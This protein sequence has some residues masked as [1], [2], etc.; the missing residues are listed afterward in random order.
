[1]D[2]KRLSVW[3]KDQSLPAGGTLNFAYAI[4]PRAGEAFEGPAEGVLV[5]CDRS[6]NKL[7]L[8]RRF[9]ICPHPHKFTLFTGPWSK[10]AD[11]LGAAKT[12]KKK[13]GVARRVKAK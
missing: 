4:R 10:V 5:V 12:A 13:R 3:W 1:M 2:A 9:C 11:R 6:K 8:V 7:F